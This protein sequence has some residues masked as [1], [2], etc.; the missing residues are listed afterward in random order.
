MSREGPRFVTAILALVS[1]AIIVSAGT[2]YFVSTMTG[3]LAELTAAEREVAKALADLGVDI[4]AIEERLGAVEEAIKPTPTPEVTFT[5]AYYAEPISIDPAIGTTGADMI[6][7]VNLYDLLVFPSTTGAPT[8][9]LATS[10]EVSEDGLTYTFHLR[11][12]VNFHD[13]SGLEAE[14]VKFTMDRAVSIKKGFSWLWLPVVEN[15]EVIDTYTVSFHLKKPFAPFLYTLYQLYIVNKDLI[16]ENIKPGEFGEFGDY[17]QEFLL[18]NDAGSG[19]FKL[20][21]YKRLAQIVMERHNDYWRGWKE[22]QITRFIYKFV[23]ESAVEKMMIWSGELDMSHDM[24]ALEDYKDLAKKPEL[25]LYEADSVYQ[26]YILLNSQREPTNNI[27]V[28]KAISYAFDYKTCAETIREETQAHGPVNMRLVGWNES[29]PIYHQDLE[30]ARHHLELSGYAPGEIKIEFLYIAGFLWEEKI[31]LLLKSNLEEIGI[32]VELLPE[33]VP[34]FLDLCS[35]PETTP[36]ATI[37]GYGVPYP[38]ADAALYGMFHPDSWG[39][40]YSAS[41]YNN[42]EVNRLLE[43][44]RAEVDEVKSIK[45]YKNI[46]PIIVEDAPAIFVTGMRHRIILWNYVKGYSYVPG[47]HH[48]KYFWTITIEK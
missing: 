42:T 12:G 28:R 19:P 9:R 31:G 39:R 14:D 18:D 1:I 34:V 43:M 48:D 3:Q 22:G 15:V 7:C 23:R 20:V 36:H 38:H 2:L 6:S 37:V 17:G 29:V 40:W 13:G 16:M 41:W 46:Q 26:I 24:L 27:H 10:W 44:A 4:A 25:V 11:E 45:L 33:P 35:K 21:E 32:E 5:F 47:Y 30:K 8:P